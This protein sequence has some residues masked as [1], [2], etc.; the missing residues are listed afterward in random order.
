MVASTRRRLGGTVVALALLLA[1]PVT[2]ALDEHAI[3]STPAANTHRPAGTTRYDLDP[4]GDMA[5]QR[6]RRRSGF[7]FVA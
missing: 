7:V 3:T 1:R 2:S 6:T 5:A 4:P